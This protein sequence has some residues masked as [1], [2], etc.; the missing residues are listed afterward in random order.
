M[1]PMKISLKLDL[2]CSEDAIVSLSFRTG[3]E[4]QRPLT[5]LEQQVKEQLQEYFEGSRSSFDL[6]LAPEGTDFQKLVWEELLKIPYGESRTYSEIAV[7]IGRPKASRAV[8]N[9]INKNPI[10]III[11]CH[12]VIGKDGNLRGYAGGLELKEMLL[13]LEGNLS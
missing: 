1:K 7:A 11:P 2:I 5:A 12:R 3:E 13:R 9:A 10:A 6:P 4:T 8:G